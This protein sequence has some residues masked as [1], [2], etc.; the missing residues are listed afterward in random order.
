MLLLSL[1]IFLFVFL[2]HWIRNNSRRCLLEYLQSSGI[3]IMM[4]GPIVRQ[5]WWEDLLYASYDERTYCMPVMM[6]GPIVRQ[7]W[8]EDLLYASYDE[9]TYCTPV[10]MRGP[11]VR[12][13]WWEDLLYASYDE[14]TYC[15]PVMMRGPIVRQLW[16]EDLLY[17]SYDE[18]IYCTPV[19]M[20]GPIVCQLC[21][22]R[23]EQRTKV[24]DE[25]HV[26][27]NSNFFLCCRFTIFAKYSRHAWV[28][29]ELILTKAT[30]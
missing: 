24:N 22:G 20:R 21:V 11:I 3:K 16:W 27:S 18:R 7:L 29:L 10:M 23:T 25:F 15:T 9:R 2:L 6:R 13:L 8:C 4:R 26:F 17:A 19:M 1:G 12:Q 30:I 5:L 28:S 14:R